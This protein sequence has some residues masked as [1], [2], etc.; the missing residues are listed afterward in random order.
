MPPNNDF[1]VSKVLAELGWNEAH[2]IPIANEE[3]QQLIKKLE[4]L[5]QQLHERNSELE[6]ERSRVQRLVD[7][8]ENVKQEIT[9][10]AGLCELRRKE[11]DD[12]NH[13][14]RLTEREHGKLQQ[15]MLCLKKLRQ[16]VQEKMSSLE[17]A[18]FTKS[19]ELEKVSSELNIDKKTLDELIQINEAK[20]KDVMLMEKYIHKDS[21]Q[22]KDLTLEMQRLTSTVRLKKDKLDTTYTRA[23]TYQLSLAG[24]CEETKTAHQERDM[25]IAQWE[26]VLKRMKDRDENLRQLTDRI[27]ETQTLV[28]QSKAVIKE[29][30]AFLREQEISAK[31][32]ERQLDDTVHAVGFAKTELKEAEERERNFGIELTA[33][34]NSVNKSAHDLESARS[35]MH[36]MRREKASKSKCLERLRQSVQEQQ[37]RLNFVV[38]SKLTEE[39]LMNEADARLSA[40]EAG[41]EQ[42]FRQLNSLRNDRFMA[43]QRLEEV[44]TEEKKLTQS[45]QGADAF[46]RMANAKMKKADHQCL[47]HHEELYKQDFQIQMLERRIGRLT[48][49]RKDYDSSALERKIAELNCELDER[50]KIIRMLKEELSH[51]QHEVYRKKRESNTLAEQSAAAENSLRTSVLEVDIALKEKEKMAATLQ[52]LMVEQNLLKLE[53]KR[54]FIGYQK[55]LDRVCNLEKSREALNLVVADRMH[56]IATHQAMLSSQYR[57]GTEENGRLK[58]EIQSRKSRIDKLIKRYEILIALMA[59]PEEEEERSQTYYIIK[60]AQ[61][62]ETLQQKGDQLDNET[63]QAEQELAALENTLAVMNG[64]NN[65]YRLSLAKLPPD[66]EEL[67]LERELQEQLRVLSIK[68]RYDEAKLNEVRESEKT[69]SQ[70]GERIE[71]ELNSYR[72]QKRKLTTEVEKKDNEIRTQKEKYNRAVGKLE[73]VKLAIRKT[74]SFSAEQR[75]AYEE[76]I[77]I[78]LVK[79]LADQMTHELLSKLRHDVQLTDQACAMMSACG[80][81]YSTLSAHRHSRATTSMSSGSSN[82]P[83]TDSTSTNSS[84]SPPAGTSV[85]NDKSGGRGTSTALSQVQ[86]GTINLGQQI[87]LPGGS[88]SRVQPSHSDRNEGTS[89]SAKSAHGERP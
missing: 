14:C 20:N 44:N 78:R 12:E 26:H 7:H 89:S 57:I 87:M 34:K 54:L 61:N 33:L 11:I 43:S 28:D 86:V 80:L 15:Q 32:A 76:D 58:L 18:T 13:Q 25:L 79:E 88:Q 82:S 36:Q 65:V 6:L 47:R 85:E 10:T 16:E 67:Q 21:S 73:K 22:L 38:E 53:T 23:Q 74:E 1:L 40:M 46:L 71:E 2:A 62:K 35:R 19:A 63:K 27:N 51:L 81:S 8:M 17:N 69:M 75:V 42:L 41:Q 24:R 70:T 60:A 52:R 4:Q 3:N 45:L 29:R 48:G 50:T 5:Q 64:C 59:P 68:L 77:Q 49:E 83:T 30:S 39:Q 56:Q 37:E 72:Y 55:R 31:E 9:Y 66:A 84:T